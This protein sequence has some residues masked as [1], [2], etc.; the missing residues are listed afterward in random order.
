MITVRRQWVPPVRHKA[1]KLSLAL[2]PALRHLDDMVLTHSIAS[3]QDS[4]EMP[5]FVR[6]DPINQTSDLN[7][8]SP[9]TPHPIQTPAPHQLDLDP[10]P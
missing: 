6:F 9:F 1:P 4:R 2:G 10:D 8:A 3:H 7:T 5:S